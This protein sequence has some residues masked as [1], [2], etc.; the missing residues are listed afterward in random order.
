MRPLL[1]LPFALAAC[2]PDTPGDKT[3]ADDT[4]APDSGDPGGELDPRFEAL[5][6][7]IEADLDDNLAT[8]ASVAVWMDGEAIWVGGFGSAHPDHEQ[9]VGRDTLFMIGSDTKKLAAIS[10]LQRVDEGSATLE[11]TVGEVVPELE[12]RWAPAFPS[13]TVHDLLTH[14]G[15]IVDMIEQNTGS[16]GAGLEGFTLGGFAE[17]AY[18]LA[19]PGR[20]WNYSNPN[21]SVA[22]LVDQ[23]LSGVAWEEQLHDGVL[24][25][26]GMDRTATRLSDVDEDAAAGFG[27]RRFD[28][29][30]FGTVEVADSWE[31]AWTRPAGL[32]WSNSLDQARLAGFLVD[33]DPAVL[34]AELHAALHG[35]QVEMYPETTEGAYGYGLMVD[36]GIS[37]SDGWHD[38]PVWSHGGNTI[39]HTSTFWILPDQRFAISILSNGYG[40]DFSRSVATAVSSLVDDLPA[41]SAGPEL[42][43]DADGLDA[44]EG[45]YVDDFNVGELIITREGDT[46]V[47]DA[48][49]LDE[50]NVPYTTELTALSTRLWL[51]DIQ[52]TTVDLMFIDG[53]EGEAYLRN[54]SFVAIRSADGGPAGPRPPMAAPRLDDLRAPSPLTAPLPR[55]R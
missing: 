44:L 39:T 4:A 11:T 34:S 7:A 50:Y 24:G 46:L 52:G 16:E 9:T 38:V 14:Q 35:A 20:I 42:P 54:R 18:P 48:P 6:A 2:S 10:L 45:S 32:L 47:V 8:G 33:G 19:P 55:P 41:P 53:P 37:L 22:G 30:S 25:P 23:R 26:L 17:Q 13:A 43:W 12:M 28:G 49:L 5:A 36:R 21:F 15:G 51:W 29:G 31:T 27:Y 40:D 1:F 3:P